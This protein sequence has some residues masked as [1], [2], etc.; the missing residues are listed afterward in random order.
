M[1]VNLVVAKSTQ[2]GT[3]TPR[4]HHPRTLLAIRAAIWRFGRN[5]LAWS[6]TSTSSW[7]IMFELPALS[8]PTMSVAR[9]ML[10][11]SCSLFPLRETVNAQRWSSGAAMANKMNDGRPL[12][13]VPRKPVATD[14]RRLNA[15][16][17]SE[18]PRPQGL[19]PLPVPLAPSQ[20]VRPTETYF[21][22]R[23]P[24][25]NLPVYQL[26]KAGGNLKQ[27]RVRKLSGQ[28]EQLH[29]QLKEMLQ[30]PPEWI[31][32]NPTNQHIEMKV[33]RNMPQKT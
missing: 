33:R 3:P 21:V 19:P 4:D 32:V 24:T 6:R 7:C 22:Q 23:T 17:Q 31:R 15:Q 8:Q 11:P 14:R 10:R 18:P 26:T 25:R 20:E 28:I 2:G 30:P 1:T 16:H 27:T 13:H 9:A 12:K 5:C 29:R